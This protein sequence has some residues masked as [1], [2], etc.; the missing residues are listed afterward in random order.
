M[1]FL[2]LSDTHGKI[3]SAAAVYRQLKGIDAIIHLG[4]LR[5]DACAL[6]RLLRTRVISVGGNCDGVSAGDA[7]KIL[8]TEWGPLLLT[9]G[10]QLGVKT[11]CQRLLYRAEELG[12][13][14]ALFGHTHAP[15]YE[16]C[17]GIFLFNP[18]SISLPKNSAGPSYGIVTAEKDGFS[19]SVAYL[20]SLPDPGR[21]SENPEPADAAEPSAGRP[22][23]AEGAKPRV[24][25][26]YLKSL[27]NHS[28]RF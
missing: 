16:E 20:S 8:D 22:S 25:G 7:E 4:D 12:C 10:H 26:G 21:N 5:T 2:V 3:E 28:D 18:G 6:S 15:Y 17:R 13:R 14:A 1:K 24:T 27:L 19:A 23:R 9:H 11:G